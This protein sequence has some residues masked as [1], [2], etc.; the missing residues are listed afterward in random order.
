MY[1]KSY[2][3]V[4]RTLKLLQS[5]SQVRSKK[6]KCLYIANAQLSCCMHNVFN[7]ISVQIQIRI[8]SELPSST[9]LV[10]CL[11]RV[12]SLAQLYI[13]NAPAR[14]STPP[15]KS[16]V[17]DRSNFTC[18]TERVYQYQFIKYIFMSL[19]LKSIQKQ[20]TNRYMT[21]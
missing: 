1:Q 20:S 17:S 9:A 14:L 3:H 21:V 2:M 12:A 7:N 18:Q 10:K 13:T 5:T 8:W 4:L 6:S 19:V 15:P 16:L 11:N